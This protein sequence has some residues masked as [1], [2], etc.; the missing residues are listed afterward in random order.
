MSQPTD[1]DLLDLSLFR[2][3]TLIASVNA[4]MNVKQS[5]LDRRAGQDPT[6][7]EDDHVVRPFL[8]SAQDEMRG[9]LVHLRASL[10]FSQHEE[11]QAIERNVRRFSDLTR[12]HKLSHTLHRVHQRLLSLFPQIS[13]ELIEEA[14]ILHARSQE[15]IEVEDI[16]FVP[17]VTSFIDR[18][19]PFCEWLRG[20]IGTTPPLL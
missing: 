7:Q 4:A 15:L 13:E 19:L 8:L 18:A 1:E 20:E 3:M 9:I 5:V 12:L 11:G 6:D 10:I 2:I 16:N 14:R 17:D